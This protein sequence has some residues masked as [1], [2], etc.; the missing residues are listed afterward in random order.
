MIHH[1]HNIIQIIINKEFKYNIKDI[2]KKTRQREYSYILQAR[3]ETTE[4]HYGEEHT[5]LY[6][7]VTQLP[8][9]SSTEGK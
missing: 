3:M 7:E 4:K 2:E 8:F 1:T 6:K 5:L 9:S